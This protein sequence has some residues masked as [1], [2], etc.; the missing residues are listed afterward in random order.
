MQ[1][2]V[3]LPVSDCTTYLIDISC[4][5]KLDFQFSTSVQTGPLPRRL[6]KSCCFFQFLFVFEGFLLPNKLQPL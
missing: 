4:V 3:S 2:G 1:I 6:P 5:E